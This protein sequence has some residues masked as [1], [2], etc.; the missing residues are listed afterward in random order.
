VI[1]PYARIPKT[2]D[3]RLEWAEGLEFRATAG[4]GNKLILDASVE[5]GGA[6]RGVRP[7]EALLSALGG[8]TGMDLVTILR[9]KK[10]DVKSLE[11]KLHG[12]RTTN[13]PH[14]F[15]NISMEY[16]I[17]GADITDQDVQ[18]ALNLSLDKYCSVAA[19]LKQNCK[20]SFRWK[21]SRKGGKSK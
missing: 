9:K 18:W 20:L 8:C 21:I 19:M 4:S 1:K 11:I 5:H 12:E 3:A 13:H 14:V 10:R 6:N 7:M 15:K 17:C 16:L 2:V